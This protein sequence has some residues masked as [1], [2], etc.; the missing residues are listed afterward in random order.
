MIF[1]SSHAMGKIWPLLFFLIVLLAGSYI[2]SAE[3]SPNKSHMSGV[4]ANPDA[5]VISLA[6]FGAVGDGTTDDGPALQAAVDALATAGGGVLFV[7]AGTYAIATP[8]SK[9]FSGLASEI[10]IHGETSS[11]VLDVAG[12]GS[13]L[14]LTSELLIKVG[15]RNDALIF[16]N[17]SNLQIKDLIFLGD[18]AVLDDAHIVVSIERVQNASIEHSE[19]YGLASLNSDGAIVFARESGLSLDQAAFLGCATSSGVTTSVLQNVLWKSI[20]VTNSKFI[21]YGYRADFFSKTP[22]ASPYSWISIGNAAEPQPQSSRREAIIQNVFLDEGGFL[23]VSSRPDY[24]ATQTAPFDIFVSRLRMNV[25]N[26]E[27]VGMYL[28]KARRV[29]VDRSYFGWSHNASGAIQLVQVGQAVFDQIECAAHADT[30]IADSNSRLTIINSIYETLETDPTLTR[31]INTVN[32]LDDPVQY[33]RQQFTDSL[34]REPD[35]AAYFYWVTLLL[36]SE[37]AGIDQIHRSL[38]SYLSRHPSPEFQITGRITNEQGLPLSAVSVELSG[39][40]NVRTATDADGRYSF[41]RLATSGQYTVTPVKAHY[42]FQ[43]QTFVET[44]TDKTADFVGVLQRHTLQG[45]VTNAAGSPISGATLTLTGTV[46]AT[47][48]SDGD[49][50][51]SFLNLPGGTNLSLSVTRQ[52]YDFNTNSVAL[53]DLSTDKTVGFTGVLRNYSVSGKVIGEDGQGLPATTVSLTGQQNHITT[54]DAAGNYSLS[55]PAESNYSLNAAKVH[56]VITPATQ[57]V[58]N[59]SSNQRRDFNAARVRYVIS[60]TITEGGRVSVNVE[61]NLTG[62]VSLT[63]TT[64]S[65]GRFSFSVPALGSYTVTAVA[66]H[67]HVMPAAVQLNDLASSQVA[68]FQMSAVDTLE[69]STSSY[70]ATEG[71][72]AVTVTV[73]R[74][75]NTSSPATIRYSTADET[76]A[77]NQDYILATGLLQFAANETTKTFSVLIIDDGWVE[78]TPET[79]VITLSHADGALV[80]TPNEATLT[81]RDSITNPSVNPIEDSLSFV[82]QQYGDFLA[83]Q[84]DQGGLSYWVNQITA[85][86]SDA[87]CIASRRVGVSAAFFV[88]SEFQQTGGFVFRLFHSTLGRRPLYNEFMADRGYLISF[89]DVATAKGQLAVDFMNRDEFLNHYPAELQPAEFIDNLLASVRLNTGVDLSSRRAAL[90]AEY[91]ATGGR[92]QAIETVAEDPDLQRAEYNR[93]FVLMQYFGYLRRDPDQGG[94]DFWLNVLNN[95]QPGN[96]RGMVCAFLTSREYQQRFGPGAPRTD[97]ECGQVQGQP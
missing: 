21:D 25:T 51:Y 14:D 95:R 22:L 75:G 32:P 3:R 81:I 46:N 40:Q 1:Q 61:V 53:S 19:F 49:G 52:N 37:A 17:L 28:S 39:S 88:E 30:I 63:T 77:Q 38:A 67:Y 48:F 44:N 93:A 66:E 56:Y 83:R 27:A 41:S 20:S 74:K 26:L 71:T 59:L 35:P 10:T 5:T 91:L 7:P 33:V 18:Q 76:A 82:R 64:D 24:F 72:P 13:G 31:V 69:F 4:S 97:Q 47:T 94:F 73:T 9:D 2:A 54:T 42:N 86:G 92:A 36:Q 65:N 60:G 15:A 78:A 12:T 62:T 90:L 84:P 57:S 70:E 79:A 11:T 45:K 58:S 87:A 6:D 34:H 16:R 29:F 89:E 85:C 8:V 23:G 68:D 80:G 50:N 96:F 55:V 43:A